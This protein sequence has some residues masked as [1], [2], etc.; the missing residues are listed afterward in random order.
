MDVVA[1][2]EYAAVDGPE[3]FLA[4]IAAQSPQGSQDPVFERIRIVERSVNVPLKK[5]GAADVM[6]K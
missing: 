5:R 4:K 3:Q 6:G 2:L 1:T